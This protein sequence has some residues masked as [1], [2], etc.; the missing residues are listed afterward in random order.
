MKRISAAEL[1]VKLAQGDKPTLLDVRSELEFHTFNIG[2]KNIPLG[3][4]AR[5]LDE[6]DLPTEEEIIVI[7]QR[8][9]RSHS[10]CEILQAAGFINVFNLSDG[11][12]GWQKNHS[13]FH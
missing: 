10:A 9:I 3:N 6:L 13:H 5:V 12:I 1:Q 8:G 4:L 11:L 7:C 2:G